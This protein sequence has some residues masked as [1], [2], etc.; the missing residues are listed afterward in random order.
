MRRIT[1]GEYF[2]ILASP[3]PPPL[4]TKE[5][6]ITRQ[7]LPAVVFPVS[8][9]EPAFRN[10]IY[11]DWNSWHTAMIKILVTSQH[12]CHVQERRITTRWDL[13]VI[14]L[15]GALHGRHS[16]GDSRIPSHLSTSSSTFAAAV[17]C[18]REEKLNSITTVS[19]AAIKP[20]LFPLFF[21]FLYN[22]SCR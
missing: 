1:V 8:E 13:A 14:N 2:K 6:T 5:F 17:E 15:S 16:S 7:D 9:A 3:H 21:F 20:V 12:S 18:A 22:N 4:A 19:V 11:V 10:V